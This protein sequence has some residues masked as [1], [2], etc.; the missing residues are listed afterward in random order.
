MVVRALFWNLGG[1][2]DL[3]HEV[4]ALA[5]EHRPDIVG[6]CEVNDERWDPCALELMA[7]TPGLVNVGEERPR[8]RLFARSDWIAREVQARS[9][10]YAIHVVEPIGAAPFVIGLAHL[11]SK[12]WASVKDRTKVA[13][14]MR[15]AL[16]DA[17]KEAS[18]RSDRVFAMGDFNADPWET[19]M[20]DVDGMYALEDWDLSERPLKPAMGE[21]SRGDES[22]YYNPMWTRVGRRGSRPRGTYYYEGAT[23]EGHRW[24][25]YD[26][27]LVRAGHAQTHGP[28]II[29]V[30]TR[31]PD[32]TSL[33]TPEGRPLG[34]ELMSD[35][36]PILATVP[37]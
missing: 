28:P 37:L 11:P 16:Y 36:F 24:H 6:L 29:R 22:V 3:S 30:V 35:H 10:L 27:A 8:I 26:T 20:T 7:L 14:A 31:M 13:S 21:R 17:E 15:S 34:K 33:L 23:K 18:V 1:R 2:R 5:R 4:A 19:V 12:L 25:G 9:D 32:G